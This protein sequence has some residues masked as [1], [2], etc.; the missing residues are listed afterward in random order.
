MKA[1]LLDTLKSAMAIGKVK[2][3]DLTVLSPG[4]DPFR[5]DTAGRHR[6]GAWLGERFAELAGRVR[7]LR[8]LHYALIGSFMPDGL[9]YINDDEHWSWLARAAKGARWLGYIR[10]D[11]LDDQ[12]NTAPI[13]RT[14]EEPNPVPWLTFNLDVQ[15]PDLDD[16]EPF[17]GV[18][19]FQGRQ[20]Y[21]LVLF[22]EKSSL[23]PVLGP[24]AERY[25]ADLYLPSGE[26]SETQT[27][28]MAKAT[29][30]DGRPMVLFTFSD[31]DPAGWQMPISIAR[32][33]QA[34]QALEFPELEFQ[35]V[36]V[37]LTPDH[38]RAY[39]LPSTPLKATEKRA[40]KWVKAQGV[41]QTEI[42][43]LAALRPEVLTELAEEAIA[44]FFDATLDARVEAAWGAWLTEAQEM[45]ADQLD[46]D[47]IDGIRMS[48][49]EKLATMQ[50]E[51]DALNKSMQIAVSGS[52]RHPAV[53]VPEARLDP[54]T[55]T[56][57]VSSS[58]SFIDQCRALISSKNYADGG[59]L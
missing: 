59:A 25:K 19:R 4:N 15:L 39:G 52:I 18:D 17:L 5:Q 14:F 13:I 11:Q 8:G 7:H 24:V 41:E 54:V 6:D 35:V 9:P 37:G 49:A 48:A 58:W 36:R 38:V 47:M 27:Y 33:L 46:P 51:I 30:E 3:A 50:A 1:P 43:A 20:P 23:E 57:L 16:I 34:F 29:A 10:F 26:L 12:R 31:S 45:L 44:P 42:D 2:I 53:V 55:V 21:K 22:G 28:M 32:K 40:D 56:P